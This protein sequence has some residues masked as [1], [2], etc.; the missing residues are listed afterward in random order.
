MTADARTA[1]PASG[2]RL[3]AAALSLRPAG[4]L[5]AGPRRFAGAGGL[6]DCSIGTPCDPPPAAVLAAM[7]SS[8]T[9]RG[10]PTSPGRR[11]T[12]AAAAGWLDRR[13][14]VA[15]D[16]EPRSA[17]CVGTKEFVA[18]AAQ[19]LRLRTPDRDTVLYPGGRPTRPTPWAPAGRLPA[20]AGARAA[21]GR[22]WTSAPS[23]AADPTGPC[24]CGP[25][26]PSNPTG[27]LTDLGRGGRVGTGPRRP[28]LL[29][30]VLRRVHLGRCRPRTVLERA[31]T[32]WWRST[33]CPSGPTWPASGRLLRR[34]PRPGRLLL[35]VRSTPGSWSRA[36]CRPAAAVALGRRRPRGGP[37]A[38]VPRAADFLA[39]VLT[40]G[41]A[42][43]RRCRPGGSTCGCR[44]PS[45]FCRGAAWALT[46]GPGRRGRAAGQPRGLYGPTGPATSGWPWS[47]PWTGSSWWPTDWPAGVGPDRVARPAR[48]QRRPRVLGDHGA[49]RPQR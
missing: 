5:P 39:G 48:R 49:L 37:A 1:D 40:S 17:A 13:F 27:A 43:G 34:G 20:G 4:R 9:E 38:A 16:P 22:A 44:Y 29:R 11:P 7:A 26:R 46:E 45:G 33:R 3:R 35:E 28:G 10:Y 41:R 12:G 19:Y 15:V 2:R 14:G 32:A 23:T 8:G 25:T 6:V 47:S 24:C 36:R 18:S 21:G 31:W 30:R 42:A